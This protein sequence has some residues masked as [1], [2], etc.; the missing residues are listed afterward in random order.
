MV[1]SLHACT[2]KPL[3]LGICAVTCLESIRCKDQVN[4]N[5]NSRRQFFC[6]FPGGPLA[7]DQNPEDPLKQE[8]SFPC[9][10]YP[11]LKP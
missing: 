4:L 3:A 6:V 7:S 11:S 2:W 1:C 10:I 5:T 9:D 8:V